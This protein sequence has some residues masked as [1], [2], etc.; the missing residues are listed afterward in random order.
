MAELARILPISGRRAHQVSPE[1]NASEV[2]A[3]LA[4]AEALATEIGADAAAREQLRELPYGV[5][6]RIVGLRLGRLRVPVSHGGPGGSIVDAI[7]LVVTLARSDSN[8]A[9]AFRPHLGFVEARLTSP[10]EAE[11]DTWFPRIVAGGLVGLANAEIGGANG[12]LRTRIIPDGD[13]FRVTGS[14]FYSTGSLYADWISG[15]A[16]DQVGATVNFV[17]PR[18]REGLRLYDD[19][20][21]MGQRLTASGTTVFENVRVAPDE[22]LQRGQSEGGRSHAGSFQQLVLAATEAGIALNALSDAVWFAQH[23]SRPAPHSSATRS[24]DDPYIQQ[25]VGEI[26]SRAYVAEA[27]VYRAAAALDEALH[28]GGEHAALTDASV[29]VAQAQY[30]AVESALRSAELLFDVGGGSATAREHNFDRHWRNAR[31]IA[32]HNPRFYK[33]AV[34]G[35]YRLTGAEPPTRASF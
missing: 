14:K 13:G 1:R 19:W 28:G 7:R 29:Q 26:S 17:V 34:V 21:S 3:L 6:Q 23:R 27:A 35:R 12:E 30:I 31:T 8:V 4:D 2:D 22:I 20:D 24:V 11:R 10:I 25:A 33:T 16:I 15:S 18:D 5:F 9:Q 32:N